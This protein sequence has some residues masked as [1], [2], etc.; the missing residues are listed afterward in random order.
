MIFFRIKKIFSTVKVSGLLME[1]FVA[2]MDAL[3]NSDDFAAGAFSQLKN[4]KEIN[5]ADTISLKYVDFFI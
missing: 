5:R 1:S 3:I 4:T 2:G